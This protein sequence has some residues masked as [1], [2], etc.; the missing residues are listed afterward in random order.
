M[1]GP[2]PT[3][4]ALAKVLLTVYRSFLREARVVKGRGT[5]FRLYG[6]LD[7]R[8]WGRGGYLPPG[9]GT[10]VQK[11]LFPAVDMARYGLE[12]KTE[13]SADEFERVVRGEFRR[14]GAFPTASAAADAA[15]RHLATLGQLKNAASGSCTTTVTK[16]EDAKAEVEVEV[17]TAFVPSLSLEEMAL[18]RHYPHT[19]RIK[20]TNKS[21]ETAVQLLS[22]HWLF[23]D[24]EG[25]V[26]VVPKGSAGVVG[27][28]P[29]LLPGQ[30]FAYISGTNI[31]TPS[32]KMEGSFRMT[33]RPSISI[34]ANAAGSASA[35][36]TT[37]GAMRLFDALIQPTLLRG[38]DAE[39]K[40]MLQRMKQ[41]EKASAAGRDDGG[42]FGG[43][44]GAGGAGG[45]LD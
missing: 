9:H 45:D 32:G 40:E 31:A 37:T 6:P 44:G 15:L 42:P 41:Q 28:T 39:V 21:P 33:T 5:P 34:S 25:A 35:S 10:S 8:N 29:V 12:G 20:I 23:T 16:D 13:L 26:T 11:M 18:M 24:A 22:R 27:Q 19:Y 14:A 2:P 4:P 1:P 36:A 30:A 17:C 7:I 38:P 43:L 3:S